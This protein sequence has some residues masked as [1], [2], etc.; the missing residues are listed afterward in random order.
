VGLEAFVVRAQPGTHEKSIGG[1][2]V[3]RLIEGIKEAASSHGPADAERPFDQC[4]S[5]QAALN[6]VYCP[7]AT[8]CL[9]R[10]GRTRRRLEGVPRPSQRLVMR[11]GLLTAVYTVPER[12]ATGA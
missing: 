1:L 10:S 2:D 6:G 5:G 11:R 7:V 12:P 8:V 3:R 9:R 4:V